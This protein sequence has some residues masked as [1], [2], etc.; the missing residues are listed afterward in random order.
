MSGAGDEEEVVVGR[1]LKQLDASGEKR[2]EEQVE[3]GETTEDDGGVAGLLRKIWMGDEKAGWQKRRLEREREE[4]ESG[5]G[6]GDII[7]EQVREVFP[8]LGGGRGRGEED[9]GNG[10]E[11]GG[12]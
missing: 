2:R 12:G 6:Y 4:L 8:R 9:D 3:N 5:K 11:E 10:G 1:D 7:M